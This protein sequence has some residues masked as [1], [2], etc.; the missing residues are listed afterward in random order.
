MIIRSSVAPYFKACI[1]SMSLPKNSLIIKTTAKL[2]KL[3]KN[4]IL[5][6]HSALGNI[7]LQCQIL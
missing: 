4:V 3:K 6:K 2:Q 5:V 1:D 7:F